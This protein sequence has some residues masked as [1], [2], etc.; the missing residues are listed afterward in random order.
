[1]TKE[2]LQKIRGL[3]LKLTTPIL[4]LIDHVRAPFITSQMC[5]GDAVTILNTLQPLDIILSIETGYIVNVIN[6]GKWKHAIIYL[7][8]DENNIPMIIE[9]IG[10]GV[11]RRN[12]YECLANKNYIAICRLK[13]NI[14]KKQV[15]NGV[16]FA[17]A[18]IGK[19]YDYNFD[20]ETSR[21]FQ[22]FY[23]SELAYYTIK[24]AAPDAQF[25]LKESFGVNT[26]IPSDFYNAKK[27]FD[28]V[29]ET[30]EVK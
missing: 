18:Q 1:M 5:L 20:M 2:T 4:K 28:V 29:F 27:Y 16:N 24:E 21:K 26:V 14:T 17:T 6:P 13:E 10:Q 12:L 11:V 23:C 3:L 25:T 8:K 19:T 9:A 7:G 22:S 15:Q 30:K